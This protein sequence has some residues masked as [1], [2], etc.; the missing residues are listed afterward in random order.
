MAETIQ[1]LITGLGSA[2]DKIRSKLVAFGISQSTDKLSALADSL[3]GVVNQGAKSFVVNPGGSTISIPA[4]WY[5]GTGTVTVAYDWYKIE[6][7][8]Y[9]SEEPVYTDGIYTLT[10]TTSAECA[11]L[12][13]Y[14]T[15]AIDFVISVRGTGVA[16]TQNMLVSKLDQPFTSEVGASDAKV[17]QTIVGSSS[18]WT[19]IT[20]S[21]SIGE[22]VITFQANK[23]GS[24]FSGKNFSIK[25]TTAGF[26]DIING[27]V[28]GGE[29]GGGGTNSYTV[30]AVSGASYGFSLNSNG[31]YESGNKGK[32]STAAVCKVVFNM[33]TAATVTISV[34]NYAESRYDYGLLS[35]I[36]TTLTT[37][38]T[39]DS[40]GVHWNGRS[41]NSS[42]VQTVSYDVPAGEHFIYI[43]FRKD[44]STSSNNDSLQFKV[45]M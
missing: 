2:R 8:D 11:K 27:G 45:N 38:S 26:E 19:E 32:D 6:K 22:H 10:T 4:G 9:G 16:C 1:S 31:Y 44:G 5:D 24:Y 21:A 37:S 20:Y 18:A 43:K 33:A 3:S 14:T 28:S 36:D 35:N 17:Q 15:K 29:T 39:A 40:S 12:T 7:G 13:F 30:E 23:T 34:I 41:N 42:S 25:L